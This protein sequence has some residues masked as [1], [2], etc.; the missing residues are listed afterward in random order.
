MVLPENTAQVLGRLEAQGHRAYAVGGCV[1]DS[2]L[3]QTPGDWDIC[4]SAR[5][6]ETAACFP[7]CRVVETGREHG[8]LTV[9]W[10]GEPFEITTFRREGGYTDHRHP[11]QVDF[12][13]SLEEDLARRDFTI[14]SMAVNAA[15]EITDLFG[16]QGDLKRRVI[17]CVGHPDRRFQED[18]LRI[19]RALRFASRLE[20]TIAPETAAAMEENRLLLGHISGERIYKELTGLLTGL[21]AAAVVERYGT[22]LTAVLPELG[23]AMGCL[24]R[25]P[26]HNRDVWGHTVEA[27]RQSRPDKLVRWALLLHDL[28]KPD[29]AVLDA[30]GIEHFHGHPARSEEIAREI[31]RR[32]RPNR[33]TAEAV[34]TLVA[35]H[36]DWL[37]VNRRVVRRWLGQYGPELLSALL[38]IKRADTL[39]HADTPLVRRRYQEIMEFAALTRQVLQEE[40]CFCLGDLEITGND[41]LAL[42]MAPGPAVGRLLGQLLEDVWEE[43]CPNDRQALLARAKKGLNHAD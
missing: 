23:P 3:G 41:L 18:A 11:G 12:V 16:G 13:S 4:T 32:L 33:E 21:G 43:R 36:D 39:A 6:E 29:C 19:L 8:T 31:F 17:R 7:D 2:L 1:R 38:E 22:V 26:G 30:R 40:H 10:Q 34:C 5:P 15:G 28:G 20:F 24:Q 37:E 42:G 14:N 27:I 9:L 25:N 35:H